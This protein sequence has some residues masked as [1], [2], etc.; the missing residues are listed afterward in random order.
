MNTPLR[1][2]AVFLVFLFLGVPF[3]NMA[4]Q[5]GNSRIPEYAELPDDPYVLVERAG[6][7]SS[8]AYHYT[9]AR[10]TT[11][12]ANVNEAGENMLGDAAN[13]PSLAIDPTNPDRMII[14]WRQ[15]DTIASNFR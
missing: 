10:F 15:F 2:I 7:A 11:V 8:P 9:T 14:G 6:R 1:I 4:Q 13:E 3:Q 5:P 12:Q